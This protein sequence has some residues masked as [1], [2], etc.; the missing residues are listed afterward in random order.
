MLNSGLCMMFLQI[1]SLVLDW[2]CRGGQNP[3]IF[4]SN[5]VMST[6]TFLKGQW[7]HFYPDVWVWFCSQILKDCRKGYPNSLSDPI[8]CTCTYKK[9][10]VFGCMGGL[11]WSNP[12]L[13][14]NLELNWNVCSIN[15]VIGTNHLAYVEV[16]EEDLNPQIR[17]WECFNGG[18]DVSNQWYLDLQHQAWFDLCTCE[19]LN[20][21]RKMDL[22]RGSK[23]IEFFNG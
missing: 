10:G 22:Q 23:E 7:P 20:G 13:G 1:L 2:K 6:L 18:K 4:S 21:W 11:P 15:K 16:L 8:F 19:G 3:K 9:N 14:I 12:N 5:S 17:Q